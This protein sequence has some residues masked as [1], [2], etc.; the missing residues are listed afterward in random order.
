MSTNAQFSTQNDFHPTY[1]TRHPVYT[2][3][4][5]TLAEAP[6]V[7]PL[8]APIQE[9]SATGI[10]R[11]FTGYTQAQL[12]EVNQFAHHERATTAAQALVDLDKA[13][14]TR[15]EIQSLEFGFYT[16]PS[17][18]HGF[19]RG[20]G[21]TE[22]QIIDSQ[23]V[24]DAEGHLNHSL[25]GSVLLPVR[26]AEGARVDYLVFS[27]IDGHICQSHPQLLR[28]NTSKTF[29]LEQVKATPELGDH[30]L[31]V[32]SVLDA[33]YLQCRGF[34]HTLA[35]AGE[36]K[37]L[38]PRRWEELADKG[39]D[40]VTLLT[41][42]SSLSTRNALEHALKARRA[43]QVLLIEDHHFS[44][45][46]SPAA[47]VQ[48]YGVEA[49]RTVLTKR[50]HAFHSKDFGWTPWK[51]VEAAPQ[52]TPQPAPPKAEVESAFSGLRFKN[53]EWKNGFHY[54][55]AVNH[56]RHLATQLPHPAEQQ[57][58]EQ[59]IQ[60]I[61]MAL[62]NN[63][64]A[65][66]KTLFQQFGQ[67]QSA[68]WMTPGFW[69]AP[70]VAPKPYTTQ[71]TSEVLENLFDQTREEELSEELKGYAGDDLQAGEVV[72]IYSTSA[73]GQLAQMADCLLDRLQNSLEGECLVITGTFTAE[74]ILLGVITSLV[75]RL[76]DDQD[77][78][79]QQV[80]MRL[81][82]QQPEGGFEFKPWVVDE[83]V[84]QV[85]G[86]A[87]R[88]TFIN[89]DASYYWW[90]PLWENQLKAEYALILFDTFAANAPQAPVT[91]TAGLKHIA[92]RCQCPVVVC[93]PASQQL[94]PAFAPGYWNATEWNQKWFASS[95]W[96]ASYAGASS[97]WRELTHQVGQW[98]GK[99]EEMMV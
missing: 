51:P 39:I 65:K 84:D 22:Q 59:W 6:V 83:A 19:L 64:L 41:G 42:A 85:K 57:W 27:P 58:A 56:L 61:D 15:E 98:I 73:Q 50:S 68:A 80:Q 14:L 36:G 74:Q 26:N 94:L 9:S 12:L 13:G 62:Q 92:E 93:Q 90:S 18:I 67:W 38:S 40:Q 10:D 76:T 21:F 28:N 87:S 45:Q 11:A 72:S 69:N 77:V 49:F 37:V 96:S 2:S 52:V 4:E 35:I 24:Y 63:E 70:P 97:A 17:D 16:T 81:S 30:V 8:A 91:H 7:E 5:Q 78:T 44:T 86:W 20:V 48:Q 29:G 33:V 99:T 60:Q 34:H 54:T 82:G 89:G 47:F 88:L 71:S 75:R 1:T 43:P 95:P 31:M 79:L 46:I 32:E 23:L 66:A 53:W 3:W 55:A 25:A